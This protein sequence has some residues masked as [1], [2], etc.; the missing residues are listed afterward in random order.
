M[1]S[2]SIIKKCLKQSIAVKESII[3]DERLIDIIKKLADKIA[4]IIKQG[5]KVLICGNGGSASDALHMA[6]E[7][8]GRFQQERQGWPAIALNGDIVSITAVANDYGYEKV[9]ERATE[10]Y[11]KS[12]DILIGISTSGN[13]ENVYRAILKAKELG[14]ITAGFLGRDGGKIGKIVDYPIIVSSAITARIQ[15]SHITIIHIICE[16][17]EQ[18]CLDFSGDFDE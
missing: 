5:G 4:A 9:F 8:V 10:A 3:E 2:S 6:G 12:N 18:E 14:G 15:E 7:I 13:S 17:V 16:L 1:D 11:M